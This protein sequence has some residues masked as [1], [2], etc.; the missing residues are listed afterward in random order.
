MATTKT[1]LARRLGMSP[2]D[3][4]S[5]DQAARIISEGSK[6]ISAES[7]RTRPI[8]FPGFYNIAGS[9][10][11]GEVCYRKEW[12]LTF[13]KWRDLK[14][15][16]RGP[17][18]EDIRWGRQEPLDSVDSPI[19]P[20][21]PLPPLDEV[22]RRI[23]EWKERERW[24]RASDILT[25]EAFTRIG[26][27]RFDDDQTLRTQIDFGSEEPDRIKADIERMNLTLKAVFHELGLPWLTVFSDTPMEQVHTYDA[28]TTLI[29]AAIRKICSDEK[30]WRE[31]WIESSEYA[32]DMPMKPPGSPL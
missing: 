14:A 31:A 11:G 1:E 7:L 32:A 28:A 12:L 3:L 6:P 16:D 27:M 30:R 13:K 19:P 10:T 8:D 18:P 17:P 21:A 29:K 23:S 22:A 26:Q 5:R 24:R 2:H 20:N 9:K 25:R 4:V 15:K